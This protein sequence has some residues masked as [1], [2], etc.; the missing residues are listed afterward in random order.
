MQS[1]NLDNW[2][3]MDDPDDWPEENEIVLFSD[4]YCNYQ[5]IGWRETREDNEVVFCLCGVSDE[6]ADAIPTHFLRYK[7]PPKDLDGIYL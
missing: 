1:N 4:M 7:Q 2:I 5:G 3:S 6:D